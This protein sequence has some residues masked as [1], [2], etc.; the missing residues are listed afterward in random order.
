MITG[1]N[2]IFRLFNVPIKRIDVGLKD[3]PGMPCLTKHLGCSEQIKRKSAHPPTRSVRLAK[4]CTHSLHTS[5]DRQ[6]VLW[7]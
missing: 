2:I 1:L 6:C 3:A 7:N 4:N 5:M